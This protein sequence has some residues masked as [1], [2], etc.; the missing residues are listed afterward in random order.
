M[1]EKRHDKWK[2]LQFTVAENVR[3]W[4]NKFDA[5]LNNMLSI[6]WISN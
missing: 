6:E 5:T 3:K 4:L 2:D 1:Y